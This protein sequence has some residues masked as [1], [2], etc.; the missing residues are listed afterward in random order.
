MEFYKY[1]ITFILIGMFA[2]MMIGFV[3]QTQ[4]DNDANS[5]ILNDS[6]FSNVYSSINS[7]LMQARNDANT[8]KTAFEKESPISE[9]GSL[10]FFSIVS[11]IR[12]L[13][14][15]ASTLYNVT[16]GLLLDVLIS[17][18]RVESIVSASLGTILVITL[19][20]IGWRVIKQGS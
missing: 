11:T 4:S 14:G 12:V 17:D 15:T 5:S 13:T 1:L 19:I 7:S 8:T 6:R 9:F 2:F 3:V 16:I 20:F 10:I 18:K